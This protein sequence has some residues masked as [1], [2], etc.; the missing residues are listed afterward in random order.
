MPRQSTFGAFSGVFIPSILTILGVIMYL[1]MGWLTAHTGLYGSLAI[2]TL[3]CA[4]TFITALSISSLATNMKVKAGGIYYIISRSFGIETGAAIGIPLFISQTLGISFYLFGFVESLQIL[5]P[6][7]TTPL[8]GS[9][10]LLALAG[11]AFYST[12]LAMKVQFFIFI[13]IGLSLVSF[14][15]GEPINLPDAP[16]TVFK[17]ASFW[18]AFSIFFPAVTG[19]STGLSMSGSLKNPHRDIPLGTILSVIV[20]FI[21]YTTVAIKFFYSASPNFLNDNLFA[22]KD[23]SFFAPLIFLGLWM[24]SLSSALGSLLAAP[25][26]LQALAKDGVFPAL[27]AKEF[28][29]NKE[30][31]FATLLTFIMAW[32]ALFLGGLDIIAPVLSMFFL[33]SYGMLNLATGFEG[34][35]KNPSWRPAFK[36]NCFVSFLGTLLCC[37]A[38]LLISV[39]ATLLAFIFCIIIYFFTRL[40]DIHSP[41]SD[42]RQGLFTMIARYSIVKLTQYSKDYRSWRPH[43]LY[44]PTTFTQGLPILQ[45]LKLITQNRSF[46]NTLLIEDE[47][48]KNIKKQEEEYQEILSQKKIKTFFKIKETNDTLATQLEWIKDCSIGPVKL[49]TLVLEFPQNTEHSQRIATLIKQGLSSK[50]NIF[51]LNIPKEQLLKKWTHLELWSDNCISPNSSFKATDGFSENY[52]ASPES[53]IGYLV[54]IL[55]H[56]IKTQAKIKNIS[57]HQVTTDIEN[58]SH[59]VKEQKLFLQKNRLSFSPWIHNLE[60]NKNIQESFFQTIKQCQK[61]D[62]SKKWTQLFKPSPNK[63][64]IVGCSNPKNSDIAWWETLQSQ[65]Q[66]VEAPFILAFTNT[67]MNFKNV[68]Q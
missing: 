58:K 68:L 56:I 28:G 34:L 51:I 62:P 36:T 19:I 46:I 2:I 23:I 50:K 53:N 27:F 54:L 31:H 57:W 20:G 66:S 12:N 14:Y 49:N 1:R 61:K 45:F 5:F 24:A 43:I 38:M 35:M 10:S 32:G 6:Q 7:L 13:A 18:V 44:L 64:L 41:W 15:L 55:G 26:T 60:N 8:I 22:M 30:P 65:V 9:V 59:L 11:L 42:M 37:M 17:T 16:R 33:T 25:R 48:A 63:L 29:E 40:R 4:I 21:I 67:S 3:A 52:E 47:N 39:H